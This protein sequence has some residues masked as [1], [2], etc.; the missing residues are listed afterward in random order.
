MSRVIS[1]KEAIARENELAAVDAAIDR[2]LR[3]ATKA[4]LD[5]TAKQLYELIN[6][7]NTELDAAYYKAGIGE[8]WE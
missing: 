2:A 6:G 1:E 8:A 7:T 4:R 3:M 5:R